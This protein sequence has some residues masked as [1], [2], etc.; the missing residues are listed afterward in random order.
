MVPWWLSSCDLIANGTV[1]MTRTNSC[2]SWVW[3][4][5][6]SRHYRD[7]RTIVDV[8][9]FVVSC[10]MSLRNSRRTCV[11]VCV[12]GSETRCCCSCVL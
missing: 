2:L 1:T 4:C 9:R 10:E 7:W 11:W 5:P 3:F 8:S 12:C 6:S